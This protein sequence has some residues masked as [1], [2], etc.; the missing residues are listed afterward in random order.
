MGSELHPS[1]DGLS[2]ARSDRCE[3]G[4]TCGDG[5]GESKHEDCCAGVGNSEAPVPFSDSG[6]T[7][8]EELLEPGI[9]ELWVRFPVCG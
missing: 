4:E 2:N 3:S 9:T 7:G 5:S 6:C 1:A 8:S